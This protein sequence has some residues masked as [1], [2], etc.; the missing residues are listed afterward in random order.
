LCYNDNIWQNNVS[1]LKNIFV[2]LP[3]PQNEHIYSADETAT[4]TLVVHSELHLY[5]YSNGS[6]R[7]GMGRHG[8]D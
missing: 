3:F 7:S 2:D 6:S 1:F 5:G 4:A 8:L